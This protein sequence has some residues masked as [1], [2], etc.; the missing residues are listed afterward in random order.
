MEGEMPRDQ[1]VFTD[2][3]ID[4]EGG[5]EA[6]AYME[7]L[8]KTAGG[9]VLGDNATT[10]PQ[11]IINEFNDEHPF[12]SKNGSNPN[13]NFTNKEWVSGCSIGSITLAVKERLLVFPV[14]VRNKELAPFDIYFDQSDRF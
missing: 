6:M 3:W 13:L 1:L 14:V 7:F 11:D 8:L 10:W 9:T 5:R 2:P 4:L 12:F